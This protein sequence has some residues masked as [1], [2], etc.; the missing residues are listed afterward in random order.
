MLP[1][2]LRAELLTHEDFALIESRVEL[3]AREGLED[4]LLAGVR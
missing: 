1:P 4:D 2:N 3:P